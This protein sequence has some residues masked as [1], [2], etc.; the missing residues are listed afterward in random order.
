MRGGID[1]ETRSYHFVLIIRFL[2]VCRAAS[3]SEEVRRYRLPRYLK[4]NGL[5]V[6]YSEKDAQGFKLLLV[7]L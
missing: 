6:A 2:R 1:Q 3:F 4:E 5:V 7:R